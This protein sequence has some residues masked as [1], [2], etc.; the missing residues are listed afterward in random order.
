MS[1]SFQTPLRYPG[2]K[3]RLGAWIAWLMRHNDISGGI[4]AEPYA[5]GAGAAL[6]LLSNQYVRHIFINDLDPVIYA[7]WWSVVNDSESLIT[8][9]NSE[10]VTIENWVKQREVLN[11]LEQHSRT[12]IGFATFFLNRTNRSGILKAGVI[13]GR[14]QNGNYKIDARY[15]KEDLSR[16]IRTIARHKKRINLT[17]LDAMN[18]IN[19]LAP[20][21]GSKSLIY[22]DPPYFNKGSQLYRN[23]YNADD[24]RGIAESIFNIDSPWIVTYDNCEPIKDIYKEYDTQEFSLI[25][26]TSMERP[27]ATEIMVYNN[28]DLPCTPFL[29]RTTRPYPKDWEK[30]FAI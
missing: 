5:G 23:F 12:E 30:R 1:S 25:Y 7:F 11:N 24:H 21:F 19:D 3:A 9:I 29:S 15:N 13:G 10:D 2:G 17:N 4:Y 28:L 26:S 6:Y 14:S 16:R 22:L 8:L 20:D 27:K 18:F